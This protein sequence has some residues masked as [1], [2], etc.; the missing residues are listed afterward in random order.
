MT[1]ENVCSVQCGMPEQ[2]QPAIVAPADAGSHPKQPTRRYGLGAANWHTG[3][4]VVL[5]RRRRRRREFAELLQA[6]VD[7]HPHER[8]H[9][10]WDNSGTHQ[11]EEIEAVLRAATGQLVLSC[12]P[13][14]SPW[15]NPTE[16]LWR[17]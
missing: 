8:V 6:L 13:T 14:Y 5:V 11:D 2:P 16:M 4:T 7:K 1:V 15:L 12:L 3:E 17:H 9:V 10:A